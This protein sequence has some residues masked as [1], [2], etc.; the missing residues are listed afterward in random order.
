MCIRDRNI[1]SYIT[2]MDNIVS[3][4][5]GSEDAQYYP[6][7]YTHLGRVAEFPSKFDAREEGIV[8]SVKNQMP[9]GACWAFAMASVMETSLL[10]RGAGIFDLDVYK[11]QVLYSSPAEIQGTVTGLSAPRITAQ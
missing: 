7:S 6:V 5:S 1:D 3:V 11:R 4:I 8:T 10:R 2:Y 9:Y